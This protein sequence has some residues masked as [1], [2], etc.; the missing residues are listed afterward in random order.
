MKPVEGGPWD[1]PGKKIIGWDGSG[2]VSQ[3]QKDSRFKVGD[4]VW[5]C[6]Q[7]NRQGCYA[8][9]YLVDER[10]ISLKPKTWSFED[11]AA[12]PLCTLTAWEC[13]D[14]HCKIIPNR[15]ESILIIAGA[16]GVGS[17]AIQIAKKVY[18]LKVI[19][20]AS[21]KE[22]EEYCINLGADAVIDHKGFKETA[23]R[24]WTE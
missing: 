2:I 11:A 4:E 21:R 10:A 7:I 6:G 12:L 16:G 8:E 9:Y 20:T 17:I 23:G 13:L 18:G 5:F 1:L 24:N 22:S 15:N 19:A 14:E 3:I